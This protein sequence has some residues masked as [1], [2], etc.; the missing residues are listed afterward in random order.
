MRSLIR[1]AAQATLWVVRMDDIWVFFIFEC[2]Q[3]QYID[4]LELCI[5]LKICAS[6]ITISHITKSPIRKQTPNKVNIA[7][8]KA[9]I[10]IK[11]AN[12]SY[13]GA[14]RQT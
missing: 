8:R 13:E 14:K 4:N 11:S 7:H 5:V 9:P 6:D 12:F 3:I 1:A 2:I 10:I